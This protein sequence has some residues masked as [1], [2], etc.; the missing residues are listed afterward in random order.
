MLSEY[1]WNGLDA[2]ASIVDVILNTNDLEGVESIEIH[3]TGDK[4]LYLT[5]GCWRTF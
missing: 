4:L 5:K 2:S 3:D 1:I